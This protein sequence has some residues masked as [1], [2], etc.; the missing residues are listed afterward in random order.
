MLFRQYL[1]R[2]DAVLLTYSASQAKKNNKILNFLRYSGHDYLL[3][4]RL[5][6]LCSKTVHLIDVY[7]L[8]FSV[9]CVSACVVFKIIFNSLYCHVFVLYLSTICHC[10][11]LTCIYLMKGNLLTY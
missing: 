8:I 9:L 3:Y 5:K 10:V 2:V 11:R 4:H 1:M 7:L 6:E